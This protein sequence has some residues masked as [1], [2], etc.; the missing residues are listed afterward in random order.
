MKIENQKVSKLSK[1]EAVHMYVSHLS[2][3]ACTFSM[4]FSKRFPHADDLLFNSKM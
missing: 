3:L 2:L 1:A 4:T